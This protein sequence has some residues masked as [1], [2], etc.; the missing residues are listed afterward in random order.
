[1][2]GVR[3]L[4][5]EDHLLTR[6]LVRPGEYHDSVALMEIARELGRHSGVKD[7]AVVMATDANKD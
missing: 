1:V 6:C 7:A 4:A 5:K 2:V 3:F